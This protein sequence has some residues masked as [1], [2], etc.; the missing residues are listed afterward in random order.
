MMIKVRPLL[1]FGSV[2]V[3]LAA[4]IISG[5]RWARGH[6]NYMT[7]VDDHPVACWR[8]HV[9]TQQDNLIANLMNETYVSPYNLA[10]SEDGNR[11]YIIGQESNELVVV[12][13]ETDRILEKIEVGERPHSVVLSND[14]DF[15]YVSNQWADNIYKIDLNAYR[16]SDTLRGGAGPAG[17]AIDPEDNYLYCVNSYSSDISIFDLNT[18]QEKRRLKAGNNPVSAALTPDGSE[19]YVSSRRSVPVPHMTSPMTE[20]TVASARYQRVSDRKMWKNAYIMENVRVTPS[21]DLVLATLIR[22]KNLIPAVQIERGWMMT[23]GIGIIERENGGRMVQLLLDEPNAYY[24]DPFGL[25]ISP[26]GKRAFVSHGGVDKVTAI[27]LDQIRQLLKESTDEQLTIYANHLGMSSRYVIG[28]IPTGANPKGM[29]VSPDGSKLYVAERLNDHIAVINAETLETEKSIGLKGPRRIT[30][31]RHG[32]QVLNNARGTFQNQYACYTCHPDSHEDGLVYNM[33]GKD[34]GRNLANVQTLRDIGDIPPYKW[35]GKNQTIYKQD[36]MRFSTILTRTEAFTHD[37]LDALVTYIITG[38]KNPPNLRFNPHGEL[39]A[40]QERGKEVFYRTHDNY[41]SEIP[42]ENRCYTCHP[43]PYFTNLEMTDVGT[44]AESDDPM[45]FD[46]PQ[47]NNVYES[48]P[49]LHDG[50]AATLEEIWTK[51][52]DHDEHG[53]A[54]DMTKDELNDLVEYLKSIGDAEYY[55]EEAEVYQ[56]SLARKKRKK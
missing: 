41:G 23:H 13:P 10:V 21:G 30:V 48:A 44:L 16:I 34:M 18:L 43:P 24:A 27:D 46:V 51:F 7:A 3:L 1:I 47:L 31:A 22:P 39:T 2:A 38:I 8:C 53:V 5:S 52:N 28:R 29:V 11:L 35:N 49:Y 12:D 14:G 50:K 56:A 40:A 4:G 15:A 55:L 36:G 42:E 6:V 19:I 26:D 54:N 25:A 37:E 32:R 33:A 20:M 45:L 17:L 9:Y